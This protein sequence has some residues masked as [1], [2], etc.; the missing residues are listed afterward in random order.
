MSAFLDFLAS[1]QRDFLLAYGFLTRLPVPLRPAAASSELGRALRLA[2]LVGLVVGVLGGL[3]SWIAIAELGLPPW[4]AALLTLAATAWI[5][6]ALHEDGLAD[7]A[8][9]WGGGAERSRKLDIMRDS[10]IGTYG[11]LALI[12]SIGL[13]AGALAALARPEVITAVLIAAHCLSRGLLP[14]AM[15]VLFPA[16]DDGLAA[17]AGRPDLPDVLTAL[18]LGLLLAVLAAGV[19][20]GLGF[21]LVALAAA[22]ATGLMA[23]RQIGGYTGDV[24]GAVQQVAEVAVLLAAAAL[25][26]A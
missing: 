21:A 11:V 20:L 25:L 23:L 15:L 17:T 2:P 26:T 24:L 10:R 7:V 4:P 1:C 9:G 6:G 18:G 5:T 16:R 19:S 3:V 12:L 22:V 13:R 14:L 8:D